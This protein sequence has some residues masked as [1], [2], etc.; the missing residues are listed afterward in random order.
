MKTT[1]FW[2]P[3]D[4]IR[5]WILWLFAMTLHEMSAQ[6][7]HQVEEALDEE[8]KETLLFL[9]RD[10]T[11]DVVAPNV[12]D[13]LDVLS[14]QGKL[15]VG[16]LAELL[17][18]VKRFD[19][20][21]QILKMDKAAV[22]AHLF[23]HPHLVSDYRVLMTEIDEDLIKSDVSSL[24]F[25]MRDYIGRGKITKDKSFLDLVIEMEKL[26]LVAPDQLDLLEKC[27][28]T[29]HRIDLKTK[30]QKYRQSAPRVGANY[31][32]GVHASLLNLTLKDPSCNLRHLTEERYRM[33]SKP[34]GICLII[35]CIGTNIE[36]LQKTFTSL[37]FK[38]QPFKCLRMCDIIR[39]LDKA[40]REPKHQDY[41]SFVCILVS[42][43]STQSVFGVDKF[44]SGF[45][46]HN[47]RKMFM[48][49]SCPYLVGK[50]KLFF[51][52]NYV[53]SESL[54][55]VDGPAVKTSEPKMPHLGPSTIHREADFF[56]SLCT[57]DVS[58]L[59]QVPSSPS[60]Y[61]QV[62][63][64]KLEQERK[65]PLLDLHVELNSKVCDWNSQVPAKK[66]YHV[67]LQHTLRKQLILS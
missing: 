37:G 11:A 20:L 33:R 21:Q 27:L 36:G 53:V 44:E 54:L 4:D 30:I 58:L 42:R 8:E 59:E 16:D 45:P 25:L 14:K 31:T 43:G 12:R 48:G 18:R 52:Q 22:E 63:S 28:E 56:W 60:L 57:A 64:Q 51:L 46:L 6:V 61:L 2:L 7:I 3:A 49:D 19:L 66:K 10:V 41:D 62:L 24:V 34:L 5:A 13:L 35:D 40:A 65:R 26:K 15:S 55:E 1:T 38:V 47:I 50:P 23:R 9:C 17:Y 39:E 67:L 32:N 29:I